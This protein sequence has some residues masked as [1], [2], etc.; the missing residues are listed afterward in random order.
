MP[1]RENQRL[2]RMQLITRAGFC[3]LVI[4]T[5]LAFIL[6][7]SIIARATA[8]FFGLCTS[9]F[10]PSYT[11]ILFWKR[12]TKKAVIASS[13]SGL[14]SIL[15]FSL[16]VYKPIA[17]SFGLCTRLTGGSKQFLLEGMINMVDP[18]FFALPISAIIL[19]VTALCT[20]DENPRI[21]KILFDKQSS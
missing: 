5:I 8:F 20:R 11:G 14:G 4:T 7:G 21:T 15:F 10:L 16:F 1:Q 18:M 9:T 6:P 17:S 13:L 3:F 19:I 12:T 2:M